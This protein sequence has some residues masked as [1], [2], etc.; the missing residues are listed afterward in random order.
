MPEPPQERDL[1]NLGGLFSEKERFD[2]PRPVCYHCQASATAALRSADTVTDLSTR[3]LMAVFA[4]PD[5]E[6][7]GTGGTLARYAAEGGDVHLVTATRGEAGEIAEPGL[8]IPANLPQVREQELRCAC[9][10]YGIHAPRFLDYVDGQLTMVHQGQAVG[11]LVRIIRQVRPQVLITFG[12]D[13]I[14]GHYDHIAVHRWATIAADLAADPDCFPDQVTETCER[15]RVSKVY[16]VALPEEQVAAM[17]QEGETAAVMMD[18]VPFRFAG[19][20]RDEITTVID[21]SDYAEAKLRGIRCHA[22]QIDPHS[23]FAETP[24]EVLSQPW[25]Q[26]EHF[27]LARSTAGRLEA[28]ETDLFTGLS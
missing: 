13:G 4:H 12:P 20:R 5:D 15:H 22:T 27:I 24:D 11:K 3:T 7:F 25:F 14:Y 16:F 8:A 17:S 18:G 6:A 1:A 2:Q 9:Q 23:P 26:R 21:V 28:V 19:R 10:I